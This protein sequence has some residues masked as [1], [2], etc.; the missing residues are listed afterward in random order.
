M[1]KLKCSRNF[2]FNNTNTNISTNIYSLK[3][4]SKEKGKDELSIN[5]NINIKFKTKN[6]LISVQKFNFSKVKGINFL[7]SEISVYN[8]KIDE[9]E[10]LSIENFLDEF[11]KYKSSK[12][13]KVDK[14]KIIIPQN[15]LVDLPFKLYESKGH[16]FYFFLWLFILAQGIFYF[17]AYI[18]QNFLI[19][20]FN[21]QFTRRYLYL[22][23]ITF[24]VNLL[25]IKHHLRFVKRITIKNFNFDYKNSEVKNLEIKL[26][27]GKI[28]KR[29]IN[30]L[31][32]NKIEI[33]KSLDRNYLIMN[34][35][36]VK[37]YLGLKNAKISD[38]ALFCNIIRGVEIKI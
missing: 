29:N 17:L 3:S 24:L 33:K 30:Q 27:S 4:L 34:S 20:K 15:N 18:R 5:F 1:L 25:F 26:F 2:I 22:Q 32:I 21:P 6:N 9:T 31:N 23:I 11:F 13:F 8:S 10:L 35:F 16:P 19:K 12:D 38:K 7:S 37:Y 28:I 36:D 14:D